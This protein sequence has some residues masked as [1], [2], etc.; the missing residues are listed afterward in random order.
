MT[1]FLRFWSF[2]EV[3]LVHHRE[4]S[5]RLVPEEQCLLEYSSEKNCS[6]SFSEV[7]LVHPREDSFRLVPEKQRLLGYSSEKNFSWDFWLL[8]SCGSGPEIRWQCDQF[9][10]KK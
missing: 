10:G 1:I 9:P 8:V 7:A 5:S 4:G 6:W 2:S 3:A